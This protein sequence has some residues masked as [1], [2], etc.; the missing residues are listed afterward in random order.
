MLKAGE[1]P[2]VLKRKPVCC[3]EVNLVYRK[4][5]E[6]E[7]CS[8]PQLICKVSCCL[9]LFIREAHVVSGRVARREREAESIRAVLLDYLKRVD[10]VAE[11]L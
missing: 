11:R 8:I 7:A 1:H 6:H 2:P 5:H 9:Y 4:V 10:A 3:G